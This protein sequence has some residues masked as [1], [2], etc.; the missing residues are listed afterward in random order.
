MSSGEDKMNCWVSGGYSHKL[1]L[2]QYYINVGT[3]LLQ[4][5]KQSITPYTLNELSKMPYYER[6][7]AYGDPVIATISSSGHLPEK[8]PAETNL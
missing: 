5:L 4:K 2:C 8:A 1:M 7:G 6:G 3:S